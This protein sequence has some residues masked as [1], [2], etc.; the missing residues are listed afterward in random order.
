MGQVLCRRCKLRYHDSK[1]KTCYHCSGI[2]PVTMI[3]P[4]CQRHKR[5]P[6]PATCLECM[7]AKRQYFRTHRQIYRRR[8]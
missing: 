7:E 2:E 8:E 5:H 6:M 3:V 4:G 1:F